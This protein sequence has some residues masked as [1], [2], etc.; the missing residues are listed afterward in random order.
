MLNMEP[1]TV[2]NSFKQT[3]VNYGG[4]ICHNCKNHDLYFKDTGLAM[5]NRDC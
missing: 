5:L 1:Y 4:D 3:D 2:F